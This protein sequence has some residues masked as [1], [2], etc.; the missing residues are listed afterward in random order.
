VV[1]LANSAGPWPLAARASA[2]EIPVI[3]FV[4]ASSA[5]EAAQLLTGFRQG[6]A[7]VGYR[8]GEN[9]TFELRW[10]EGHYDRL[11][12]LVAELISDKVA[13][14]VTGGGEPAALAAKAATSTIPI[15]FGVG[16]NPVR[17]GL[18]DSVNHPGG[19]ATGVNILTA[20]LE[21]KRLEL[22][23]EIVP[24]ASS[25]GV[26]LNPTLQ[27]V[28][29]QTEELKVASYRLNQSI[30]LLFAST[31]SELESAF[32]TLLQK[33]SEGLLVTADPFF[34]IKRDR[35]IEFAAQYRL[36]AIYQFRENVLAG[37]LISYG[38]NRAVIPY[39]QMGIYAGHI[40]KGEKP[41]DMPVLQADKFE[42]VI[43]LK[44]AATLGLTF[45]LVV[46]AQADEMIQ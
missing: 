9:V 19:N 18:I 15:V 8:E 20:T 38:I 44:T 4:S 17:L 42:L 12:S 41:A 28:V 21:A 46:A 36:P 7:T 10:A 24:D 25:I 26:L 5:G 2:A 40:L 31:D 1:L 32:A 23:H 33:R 22:L 11:P 16:G 37:G 34:D 35:I 45:P 39:R 29:A 27:N 43:N 30:K 13:V 14:I 3:G 6:L